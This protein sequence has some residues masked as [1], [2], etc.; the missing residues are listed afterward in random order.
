MKATTTETR[1][2]AYMKI[3][4]TMVSVGKLWESVM[5]GA[6]PSTIADGLR[7]WTIIKRRTVDCW[8]G[9]GWNVLR[10]GAKLALSVENRPAYGNRLDKLQE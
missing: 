1:R 7:V 10:P 9:S 6:G 3:A 4:A 8:F 2:L 5:K